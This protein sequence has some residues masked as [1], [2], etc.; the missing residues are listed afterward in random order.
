MAQNYT[1]S[2]GITIQGSDKNPSGFKGVSFSPSWTDPTNPQAKAKKPFIANINRS[3]VQSQDPRAEDY[4]AGGN[5]FH[6]GSF[7]D[8]RQAAYAVAKFS[9]NVKG[10]LDKWFK[11]GTFGVWGYPKDLMDLPLVTSDEALARKSGKQP[12]S[13]AP[14]PE[15]EQGRLAAVE[16]FNQLK[17]DPDIARALSKMTSEVLNSKAFPLL[18]S[19]AQDTNFEIND[20]TLNSL[21][22]A[23]GVMSGAL[24]ED[25]AQ[26]QDQV[27]RIKQLT[28]TIIKR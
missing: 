1:L 28:E 9:T 4:L 5:S 21:R 20:K 18:R 3:R 7:D 22:T 23:V 27:D 14:D 26:S 15:K 19:K 24:R 16:K 12:G 10:Y 6:L 2:D 8:P 25:V 13:T 17:S 11:S